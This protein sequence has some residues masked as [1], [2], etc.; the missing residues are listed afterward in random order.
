MRV[1]PE[2]EE[3]EGRGTSTAPAG[4]SASWRST[5]PTQVATAVDPEPADLRAPA[6]GRSGT[7]TIRCSQSNALRKASAMR[8]V[9]CMTGLLSRLAS[10]S[11]RNSVRRSCRS[12]LHAAGQLQGVGAL[13]EGPHDDPD[14]DEPRAR[15][16]QRRDAAA[17]LLRRLGGRVDR[18]WPE[19]ARR[20]GGGGRG[21]VTFSSATTTRRIASSS[22]IPTSLPS[23][24]TRIGCSEASAARAALADDRGRRGIAGPSS[25]VVRAA[26][27]ASPTSAS[28]RASL[29]TSETKS[30]T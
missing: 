10:R 14:G 8:V 1:L 23:S 3:A 2:A 22:T 25:R 18:S 27:R 30:A 20:L 17:G 24:T 16:D 11:S 6:A 9:N 12:V 29:G 7:E 15:S 26:G 4:R 19:L 21:A 28:A 5:R 13:G